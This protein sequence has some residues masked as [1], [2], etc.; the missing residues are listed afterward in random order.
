MKYFQKSRSLRNSFKRFVVVRK[1]CFFVGI[2]VFLHVITFSVD[3]VA[4][5]KTTSKTSMS[6]QNEHIPVFVS[7]DNGYAPYVATTMVSI[8]K[9]TKSFIDYYVLDGG[10]SE[11]NQQKILKS[12]EKWNNVKVHFVK[13]DMSFAKGIK[14]AKDEHVTLSA[15]NRLFIPILPETKNV[16]K[17]IYM[18]VDMIA[19]R[20]IKEIYDTNLDGNVIGA[21]KDLAI[22]YSRPYPYHGAYRMYRLDKSFSLFRKYFNSGLLLID[23]EK[24]RQGNYTKKVLDN[25]YKHKKNVDEKKSKFKNNTFYVLADQDGLNL[26]FKHYKELPTKF[27]THPDLKASCIKENLFCD[28]QDKNEQ[29]LEKKL[30][31]YYHNDVV[32][33]HFWGGKKPWQ[34]VAE[35]YMYDEFWKVALE[36]EF[37]NDFELKV[38]AITKSKIA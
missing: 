36:T 9:H 24:W 15:Y 34:T 38:L 32:I 23:C 18:D 1:R 30:D 29:D 16:K 12:A 10:I 4:D 17:A 19:L 27:N 28:I 20:D 7:S 37:V 25:V 2:A 31:D 11:E 22:M 33:L 6:K 26:T 8:L 14:F 3:A 5:Q 35:K 13:I 21:V